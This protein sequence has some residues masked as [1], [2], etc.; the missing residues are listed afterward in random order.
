MSSVR[1]AS[2]LWLPPHPRAT[3]IGLRTAHNRLTFASYAVIFFFVILALRLVQL[4]AFNHEAEPMLSDSRVPTVLEKSRATITDRNGLMIATSLATVSLYANPKEI[5]DARAAARA[6][7][8]LLRQ[9][10]TDLYNKL[11]SD[12]SFFWL[13]RHLPPKQQQAVNNL[14]I[15]GIYFKNDER[16][17]YTQGELFAHAVGYTDIDNTGLSGLERGLNNRLLQSGQPLTTSLDVRVQNIARQE[18]ASGISKFNAIGGTAIVMDANNFEILALVSLPDFDPNQP[19]RIRDEQ[20]FNRGT[21]G[22]YEPGSTFKIFNSALVLEAG[23]ATLNTRYDTTKPI[24]IGRFTINDYHPEKRPLTVAEIFMHSSNIGSA[25][26]AMDVGGGAQ[27]A[28]LKKFGLL[29]ANDLE[30][31]ENGRPMVPNQWGNV[32][33]MTIAFGHGIAITPLQLVRA[34]AAAINGG[35]LGTPT[36]LKRTTPPERQRVISARTSEQVRRLLRLVVSEGTGKA[37]MVPG[38]LTGGKTGTA[39]KIGAGGYNRDARISSFIGAFPMDSP[40]YVIYVMIDEPKPTKESFGFAT[41]GWVAAPVAGKI[42][43]QIG[44]ILGIPP[45]DETSATVQ[46]SLHLTIPA[47]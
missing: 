35:Y 18:L 41:G 5:I 14:G 17:V 23:V 9:N 6:L 16:R 46:N 32:N 34:T 4:M 1:V 15:P 30:S 43:S 3:L 24:K 11:A 47:E 22:V 28:F 2:R 33:T 27:Q 13:A 20:R 12:R 39:E 38:Y 26:M 45:I 37:A 42:I 25:H 10:E 44:P 19:G 29:A 21:L 8:P 36:L 40:Q 31:N 7:A